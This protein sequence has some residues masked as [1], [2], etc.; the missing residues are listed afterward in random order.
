[1]N[2]C[3]PCRLVNLLRN[4]EFRQSY[5]LCFF[6]LNI[7]SFC[8]VIFSLPKVKRAWWGSSLA[9]ASTISYTLL[10]I[11]LFILHFVKRFGYI[12]HLRWTPKSEDHGVAG[13]PSKLRCALWCFEV[14]MNFKYFWQYCDNTHLQWKI[15]FTIYIC[16]ESNNHEESGFPNQLRYKDQLLW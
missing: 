14:I 6:L 12:R 10:V 9:A 2:E 8:K 3:Q 7:F 1:M 13:V 15:Q 11:M 5:A 16:D 4:F